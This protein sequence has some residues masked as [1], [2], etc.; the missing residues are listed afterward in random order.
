MRTRSNTSNSTDKSA[1]HKTHSEYHPNATQ[2]FSSSN[3]KTRICSWGYTLSCVQV[4]VQVR[5]L[6]DMLKKPNRLCVLPIQI[7]G[8]V[9]F[10]LFPMIVTRQ[11][12]APDGEKQGTRFKHAPIIVHHS[13]T[14]VIHRT[15][16]S[17]QLLPP[18]A[19]RGCIHKRRASPALISLI[20]PSFRGSSTSITVSIPISV[21]VVHR[22]Y[23]QV[24]RR[25]TWLVA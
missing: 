13:C 19:A 12:D 22:Q 3:T 21:V 1:T 23:R 15:R 16:L 6:R 14:S 8:L 18:A 24:S 9:V 2:P 7:Q 17:C 11:C 10:P 25:R 20:T 5:S 4:K